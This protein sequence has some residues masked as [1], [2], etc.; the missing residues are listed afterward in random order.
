MVKFK[1][2]TV[3]FLLAIGL[4]TSFRLDAASAEN[5]VQITIEQSVLSVHTDNHI[6]LRY[7]YENVP[8]KPYAQQLFSPNG[9][10]ILRDAPFDHLHHHGLMFAVAVEGVN[11]WEERHSPGQQAHRAFNDVK[12]DKLDGVPQAS[13][14][15]QIDWLNPDSK[16]LLLKEYRSLKVCQTKD[17]K[18]TLLTWQSRFEVPQ[19]KDFVTLTGSPYFGLGMRFLKSMDTDGRFYNADGKIGVE[20]TNG[21]QA[22]WCAYTAKADGKPVTV[23]MFSHPTNERHPATW[24]TLENHFAYLSLTMNLDKQPLKTAS[25]KPLA[26]RYAVALW[27][28]RIPADRISQLYQWW[29]AQPKTPIKNR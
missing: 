23:A 11:F 22:V 8:F 13:F 18:A 9:V 27:D 15:E 4:F 5:P 19:G 16:E 29:I 17:I 26:V 21:K 14:T 10:N 24:F 3:V 7:C 28:G 1:N 6:M 25:G 2:I 12:I 20:G